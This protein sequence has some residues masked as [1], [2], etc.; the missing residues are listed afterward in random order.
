MA[1]S[2][3]YQPDQQTLF[4]AA[5]SLFFGEVTAAAG[6]ELVVALPGGRS[7]VGFL[8]LLRARAHELPQSAWSR[9]H[10]FM[11]DERLVPLEDDQSNYRL[12]H[13]Q[14]LSALV[15]DGLIQEKQLHP[16]LLDNESKDFGVG[17]YGEELTRHGGRFQISFVGVGE[18][19]HI[20]ALFP[21]HHSVANPAPLFISM[22]DSP[23]PPPARMTASKALIER[24]DSLFAI[25]TGESKRDAFLR[26]LDPSIP[27]QACPAKIIDRVTRG[28]VLT[29]LK[30]IA[31]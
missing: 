22:P 31:G 6:S 1:A 5:A 26:Y 7:I 29:D 28:Y 16:F 2:L 13:E 10:F 18:D 15:S 11:V 4:S 24:S 20:A 27:E 12:V 8:K 19:A 21:N 23:K 3:L 25:F 9:L 30:L 14:V 17:R